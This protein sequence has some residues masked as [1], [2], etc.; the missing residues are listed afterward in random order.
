MTNYEKKLRKIAEHNEKIITEHFHLDN[1]KF[2]KQHGKQLGEDYRSITAKFSDKEMELALRI[3]EPIAD[4][5]TPEDG[6]PHFILYGL[7]HG[8]GYGDKSKFKVLDTEDIPDDYKDE[9]THLLEVLQIMALEF[10]FT[11]AE[12][13]MNI[14]H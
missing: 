5:K 8:K 13:M 4:R 7:I 3:A 10:M 1:E 6:I 14:R 9:I 11:T 12:R 2:I